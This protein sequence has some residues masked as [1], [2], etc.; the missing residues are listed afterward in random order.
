MSAVIDANALVAFVTNE[1]AAEAVGRMLRVWS[2]DDT[3]LHSPILAR[4]EIINAFV[5][6]AAKG[7]LSDDALDEAWTVID[8][9][10]ISYHAINN[11]PSVARIA[12]TLERRSAYDAAYLALAQELDAELWT[13]DGLE[14]HRPE[15]RAQMRAESR[16]IVDDRSR[17][18]AA[19]GF[20]VTQPVL[21]GVLE[22]HSSAHTTGL[23]CAGLDQKLLEG[24]L[25][26]TLT[27]VSGGWLPFLGPVGS[28]H[29]AML[30]VAIAPTDVPCRGSLTSAQID[31]AAD[32]ALS[33]TSHAPKDTA[34]TDRTLSQTL[35]QKSLI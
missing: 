10:P 11:A 15:R 8:E 33:E 32:I 21:G 16:A 29:F 18:Q 20:P 26:L 5:K 25:R 7:T 31:V 1:E 22:G 17:L 35:S 24:L 23:A 9:L 19:L 12:L 30:A 2:A 27:E 4:Y 14:S 6:K 3:Q 28:E 13:L 34:P